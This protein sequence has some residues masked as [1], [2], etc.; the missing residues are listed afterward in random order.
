ME[1]EEKIKKKIEKINEFCG[2]NLHVEISDGEIRLMQGIGI[3]GRM[4]IGGDIWSIGEENLLEKL[5]G[6]LLGCQALGVHLNFLEKS[7]ESMKEFIEM[8]GET[9][10]TPES[11]EKDIKKVLSK[12]PTIF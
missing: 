5:D 6:M 3:R 11:I 8:G 1:F 10:L 4:I 7:K 2:I 9:D 12:F